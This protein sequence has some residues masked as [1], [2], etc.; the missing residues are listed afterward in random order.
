MSNG[1]FEKFEIDLHRIPSFVELVL[2]IVVLFV[3]SQLRSGPAEVLRGYFVA[4]RIL[5]KNHECRPEMD[6]L[7]K[8]VFDFV[9]YSDS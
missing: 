4:H 6:F 9:L 2:H 8:G 7:L 1:A 5:E 3:P